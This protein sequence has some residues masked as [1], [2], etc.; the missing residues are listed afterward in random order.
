MNNYTTQQKWRIGNYIRTLL[1]NSDG[2]S[3]KIGNQIYPIVAPEG[4]KGEFVI[5]NRVSYSKD[6]SKMGVT[7]ESCTVGLTIVSDSYDCSLELAEMIDNILTGEHLWNDG[8]IK[9]SLEDSSETYTEQKYIQT[10]LF[11][12][13]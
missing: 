5:Y 3:A 10:L 8:R 6:W 12:I 1:M 9:I 13:N 7:K 4:V 11:R 2:L